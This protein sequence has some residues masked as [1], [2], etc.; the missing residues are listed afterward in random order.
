MIWSFRECLRYLHL[1]Y[2]KAPAMPDD[3]VDRHA[4]WE[5]AARFGILTKQWSNWFYHLEPEEMWTLHYG[6]LTFDRSQ[7]PRK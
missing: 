4:L 3:T 1:E 5:A 6:D 2:P 7:M